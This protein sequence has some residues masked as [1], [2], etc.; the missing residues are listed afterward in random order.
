MRTD[1]KKESGWR[2]RERGRE[3]RAVHLTGVSSTFLDACTHHVVTD[4]QLDFV[5]YLLVETIA[6]A[7]VDDWHDHVL[8]HVRH[9]ARCT[10]TQPISTVIPAPHNLAICS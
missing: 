7:T 6:E 5:S 8:D 4:V 9:H 1:K 3:G 10:T 2:E